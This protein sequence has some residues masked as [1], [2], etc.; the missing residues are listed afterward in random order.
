MSAPSRFALP[1]RMLHWSMAVAIF[2]M[3]LIGVGMV[4]TSSGR[5]DALLAWHRPIGIAVLVL[6]L[7]RLAVR[8][9]HRAPSLPADLPP[10]QAFAAKASHWL[11]YATMVALPLI[12]WAM[13]SAGGYPV[14]IWKGLVLP[15][16]LPH[17]IVTYGLLRR[18]HGVIAYLFFALILAHLAA[19]LYHGL[20]R[21]DGV[22]R[23]MTG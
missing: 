5:Y 18:A 6:A 2:A 15:P 1:A 10:A 11:L 17:D 12:G 20:V 21:R 3:L 19:A 14:E 13:Q 22:L 7:I 16:I 8:F 23:S 9:T 4:S